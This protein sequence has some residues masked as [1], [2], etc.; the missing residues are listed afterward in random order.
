MSVGHDLDAEGDQLFGLRPLGAQSRA[1]SLPVRWSVDRAFGTPFGAIGGADDVVRAQDGFEQGVAGA[2]P[3]P[4][5]VA[6]GWATDGEGRRG[7][8]LFVLAGRAV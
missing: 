6:R 3:E 8:A 2:E 4:D 5:A 1:G 7:E